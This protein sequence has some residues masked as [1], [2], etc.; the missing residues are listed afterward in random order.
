MGNIH[1]RTTAFVL[2][3]LLA[4]CTTPRGAGFQSE[5]LAA[6]KS[7]GATQ[8]DGSPAGEQPDFSVHMVTRDSLP[9]LSRWPANGDGRSYSW[10][11]RRA[12]SPTM[13]I[14]PG[15]TLDITIWDT[16]D[17]S[18]LAGPGQRV[19]QLSK[20]PVAA[21]GEVFLPFVGALKLSGMSPTAAR[22]KVEERFITSI[23]SAQ[24][25]LAVTQGR[26]N[27]ANLVAG[28]AR[29]GH[30]PLPDRDYTLLSLLAQGGGVPA[31]LKNPQVRLMR[32]SSVHGIA[33]SRLYED[34]ALDTTLQGGDRI[35]IEEDDR[36]FLSLGAARSQAIHPFTQAEVSALE[37]VSTIGGLDSNRA[38]PQGILILREYPGQAVRRDGS[39]PPQER[40]VF[41]LDLT[42]ADGL[43][44][45]GKFQVMDGDLVYATESAVTSART[46]L[47]LIGSVFGLANQFQ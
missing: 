10:I 13:I 20:V 15:D 8:P 47:S 21:N 43:F 41:V 44:S 26:A 38:N 36:T 27:T 1:R 11:A 33:L 23:P 18:L 39:G 24:V 6:T 30:Y 28:V 45:A 5:V 19:A 22:A 12:Q 32:G 29:P 37:A 4:G 46:V 9:V 34:P 7:S 17:N 14:A 25:Q 3:I 42:S 16:E 40:M 2:C 31:S 35:I